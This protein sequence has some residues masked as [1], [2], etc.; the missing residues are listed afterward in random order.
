MRYAVAAH[1]AT[2]AEG[3]QVKHMAF[4]AAATALVLL[5][6]CTNE[7]AP[8]EPSNPDGAAAA[9]TGA[10]AAAAPA[11]AAPAADAAPFIP[12]ATVLELMNGTIVHAAEKFWGSVAV[13]V[14]ADG[15]HENYPESEEEWEEVWAAA[16]TIAESGNLLMMAPRA[17]DN[18]PWQR[19]SR[20]L[21]DAG[22]NAAA[23]ALAQDPELIFATGEEVYNVCA[24]C[25]MVYSPEARE[26]RE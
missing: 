4:F 11:T 1:A 6:G 8:A 13:I 15:V 24:G 18:G 23:A 19:Y 26:T 10:P 7:P 16:I 22:S 9:P 25:H 17:V 5:G 2:A 21:I 14:D 12:V 20:R 3:A